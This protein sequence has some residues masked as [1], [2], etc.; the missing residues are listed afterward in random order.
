MRS[1]KIITEDIY[2][3]KDKQKGSILASIV[4]IKSILSSQIQW[5]L[6]D[7]L[8]SISLGLDSM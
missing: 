2:E 3:K 4:I 7:F 6:V 1:K 5:N 8:N